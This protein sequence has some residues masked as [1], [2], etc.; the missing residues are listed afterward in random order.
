M[1]RGA[2]RKQHGSWILSWREEV[3][4]DGQPVVERRSRKLC[5]VSD[6]YRTKSDVWPLADD[7][8]R[9][10]NR[11]EVTPEGGITVGDFVEKYFLPFVKAKRKPSTE[12]F[13][14]DAFDNHV[15]A[16]AGHVRL[17]DFTARHA[18]EILDASTSLAHGSVLRL[19]TTMSAIFSHAIRLGFLIGANPVRETRAEGRRTDPERYAYTLNEV[20]FMLKKLPEPARTVVATASFSGLRESELRGLQWPDY[21]G[22]F[23]HV[24]RSVWRTHI[25]DTKTPESRARVPVIAPLRKALEAHRK[26]DGK[27]TWIFSGE[28]MGRPLHLDNLSRRVIKPI[29]KGRWHGWH[30]FRRGLATNLYELGVPAEVAQLILRHANV[31]TT[32]EHYLMLESRGKGAAAMRK[33]ERALAKK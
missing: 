32:R 20:L 19:K 23:V 13:Y 3:I 30:A 6:E 7:V 1:Q 17:K 27:A 12:K 5:R 10:I 31:S 22:Q 14:R 9:P 29:L 21:D 28:K 11:N 26:R 18:Q 4:K 33:L 2:L 25:G 16:R 24:R 15:S 8:L